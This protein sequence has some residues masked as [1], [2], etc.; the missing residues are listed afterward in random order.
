MERKEYER[1][2]LACKDELSSDFFYQS[3]DTDPEYYHLM[4]KND[5]YSLEEDHYINR[6]IYNYKNSANY[7]QNNFANKNNKIKT[8]SNSLR[9]NKK[10]NIL[11][12]R[13]KSFRDMVLKNKSRNKENGNK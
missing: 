2:K 1:F 8:S 6:N 13:P 5:D 11:S 4:D 9:K 10:E 3:N 7:M 12:Q